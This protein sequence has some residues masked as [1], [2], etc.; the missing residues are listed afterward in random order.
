MT[1]AV[2]LDQIQDQYIIKVDNFWYKY[3][4]WYNDMKSENQI[5][6]QDKSNLLEYIINDK[7]N[8]S[9][10]FSNSDDLLNDLYQE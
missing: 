4:M 3:I 2:L 6:S 5:I 10:V 1:N 7:K 8:Y 9:K